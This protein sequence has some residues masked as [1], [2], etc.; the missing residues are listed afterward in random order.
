[1]T[2][3]CD[4]LLGLI[5]SLQVPNVQLKAPDLGEGVVA[6]A[7]EGLLS[8]GAGLANQGLQALADRIR[9]TTEE[10]KGTLRAPVEEVKSHSAE[11]GQF[12]QLFA[13]A[14]GQQTASCRT[15]SGRSR[16][17]SRRVR[18]PSR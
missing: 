8:A 4:A 5:D 6:E 14:A 9:D 7:A 12:L 15:G 2:S 16:R 10:A 18:T 13:E 1:V 11:I 3:Q 17:S